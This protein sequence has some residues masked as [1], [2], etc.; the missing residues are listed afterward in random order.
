MRSN[1][2]TSGPYDPPLSLERVPCTQVSAE[3]MG[4]VYAWQYQSEMLHQWPAEKQKTSS[5]GV[6]K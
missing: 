6:V 5:T 3:V 4:D 1:Q 2:L